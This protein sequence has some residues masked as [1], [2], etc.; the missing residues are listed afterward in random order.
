MIVCGRPETCA[1]SCVHVCQSM[2]L[3][4][5]VCVCVCLRE[6]ERGCAVS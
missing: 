5:R 1:V 4:L 6:I 3:L 2:M